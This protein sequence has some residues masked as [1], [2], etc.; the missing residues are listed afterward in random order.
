M[1]WTNCYKHLVII[2][3]KNGLRAQI[4]LNPIF[5]ISRNC[6]KWG[7]SGP[8]NPSLIL[9]L[10]SDT[11]LPDSHNKEYIQRSEE[12][13]YVCMTDVCMCRY[14][15]HPERLR[16]W[17]TDKTQSSP[18]SNFICTALYVRRLHFIWPWWRG[19]ISFVWRRTEI[20]ISILFTV[21]EQVV[22]AVRPGI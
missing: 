9:T 13:I 16:K 12:H 10:E 1:H 19:W 7:A 22:S 4:D 6:N 8:Y 15:K 11:I 5:F 2:I 3:F 21:A 18:F 14:N 20:I 17:I